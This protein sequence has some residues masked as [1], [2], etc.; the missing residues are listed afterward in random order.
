[1]SP[2][3]SLFVSHSTLGKPNRGCD[4]EAST[5]TMEPAEQLQWKDATCRFCCLV[6]SAHAPDD[7]LQCKITTAESFESFFTMLSPPWPASEMD[8][9]HSLDLPHRQAAAFLSPPSE[10]MSKTGYQATIHAITSVHR[11][12]SPEMRRIGASHH[13]QPVGA[14]FHTRSRT[15]CIPFLFTNLGPL[16]RACPAILPTLSTIFCGLIFPA[17]YARFS[18]LLRSTKVTPPL[19]AR[20]ASPKP[21]RP[22]ASHPAT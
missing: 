11:G 6:L 15:N 12:F 4:G 17:L 22:S 21:R 20:S 3:L 7:P 19:P 9:V 5:L 2:C 10:Y 14:E 8:T 13:G 16:F 1:M 18:I